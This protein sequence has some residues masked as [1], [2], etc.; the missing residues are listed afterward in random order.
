MKIRLGNNYNI[1]S[2]QITGQADN[3]LKPEIYNPSANISTEAKL[4]PL[5]NSINNRISF[6]ASSE[7]ILARSA[8]IITTGIEKL[9]KGGHFMEFCVVDLLG[10]WIPRIWQN[11]L[12]NREELGHL[13]YKAGAEETIREI[14][15]GPS[16]FI[17][18]LFFLALSNKFFGA[19]SRVRFDMAERFNA[20]FSQ[21]CEKSPL[22]ILKNPETL[23]KAFY[24]NML[25]KIL[26]PYKLSTCEQKQ[27]KTLLVGYL[28]KLESKP[29]L[30]KW[31]SRIFKQP[32]S[33]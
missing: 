20:V 23:K 25:D 12:R 3:E 18:P 16:M 30:W 6:T 13:N 24:G 2:G 31:N 14:L 8:D 26:E 7:N 10:M 22:N 19:A 5:N 15:T 32:E 33:F 21:V 9:Q 17:I 4:L 28:K 1:I 11:L 29:D 27:Y